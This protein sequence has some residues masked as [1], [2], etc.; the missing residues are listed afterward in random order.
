M[1][2]TLD[3]ENTKLEIKQQ[4]K[5]KKQARFIGSPSN[6]G[7]Y[8][9]W[10]DSATGGGNVAAVENEGILL[11]FSTAVNTPEEV[12]ELSSGARSER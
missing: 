2:T 7:M 10:P 5:Q 8:R 11:S 9:N 12:P 3:W 4:I 1:E 6:L